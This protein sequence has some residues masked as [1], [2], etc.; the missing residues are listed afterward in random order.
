MILLSFI[1]FVKAWTECNISDKEIH[2]LTF[3]SYYK[4]ISKINKDTREVNYICIENPVGEW[5]FCQPCQP[6]AENWSYFGFWA[7]IAGVV[8][9]FCIPS[10]WVIA[11]CCRDVCKEGHLAYLNELKEKKKMERSKKTDV[12]LGMIVDGKTPS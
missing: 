8:V 10:G 1:L 6:F 12:E 11:G 3:F 4:E 5:A 2:R 7:T 9:M